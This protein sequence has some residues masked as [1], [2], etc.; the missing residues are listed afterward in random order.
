MKKKKKNTGYLQR[1]NNYLTSEFS[2]R[3]QTQTTK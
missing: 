1:S 3:K 2:K